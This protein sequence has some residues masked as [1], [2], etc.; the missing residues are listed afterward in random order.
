MVPLEDI[1]LNIPTINEF[2]SSF[3]QGSGEPSPTHNSYVLCN[4]YEKYKK[5]QKKQEDTIE[6]FE[7]AYSSL[8]ESYHDL[9]I[10]HKKIVEREKKRDEFFI[11]IWKAIK[12][13]YK[14]LW[15]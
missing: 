8:K 10:A 12:G 9:R 2:V 11:R 3:P 1:A 15:P 4:D 7:K 5:D 14:V 6:K 13:L